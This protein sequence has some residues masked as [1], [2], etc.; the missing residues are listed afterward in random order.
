MGVVF[1]G[2]MCQET[3]YAEET[4]NPLKFSI[5]TSAEATDNRDAVKNNKQSNVDFRITPRLDY[6]Y[7][8]EAS[9]VNLFYKPS[10][11][12]RTEPGDT[13]DDTLWEQ[14][15]GLNA[16]HKVTERTRLRLYEKFGYTDDPKIEESGSVVRGN[17]TYYAN[18]IQGVFNT[19]LMRYSNLDFAILNRIKSYKDDI[20]SKTSD[21]TSTSFAAT[22]R[23]QLNQT[24]RSVLGA[25]YLIYSYD[26]SL[27]RDFNSIILKAGLEN[28]FTPTVLGVLTA[29][30]QT[31]D[32]D[33]GNMDGNDEPYFNASL[34]NKLGG[35]LTV[36]ASFEH[37]IRDADAY[38]FAS[39]VYSEVRGFANLNVAPEIVLGVVGVYRGSKYDQ[40]TIPAGVSDDSFFGKSKSGDET[41]VLG[42]VNLTFNMI[43]NLSMFV[44]YRYEYIDSDVAQSYTRNTGRMGASL[45][46]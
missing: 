45:S 11:R 24:L 6:I 43:Q 36:G 40:D 13:A 22:H 31:R 44:G 16:T 38:P 27:N 33:D 19:D 7:N 4:G 39:Q 17:H 10:L 32:Y 15:F 26:N 14:D 25:S 18:T 46:F 9:T 12:Y 29:G 41:T 42:D 23:Y 37:G 2:F 1:A 28:Q 30:V 35:D 34:E 20:I 8:G 5:G 21:E 3:L